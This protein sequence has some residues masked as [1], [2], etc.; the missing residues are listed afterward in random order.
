M[1]VNRDDHHCA[2][3]FN[4]VNIVPKFSDINSRDLCDTNVTFCGVDIEVPVVPANMATITGIQMIKKLVDLNM[5][6]IMHRFGNYKKELLDY[7]CTGTLSTCRYAMSI[8]V[9]NVEED[10]EFIASLPVWP[11]FVVIDVA[12][13]HHQKVARTIT[14]LKEL[15]EDHLPV[16]AGN[17]ATPEGAIFLAECGADAVK[18]GVGNGALCETRIRTGVGIP[19][20]TAIMTIKQALEKADMDDVQIIADGGVET[21]GDIAKAIAAGADLVMAGNIFSGTKETPGPLLKSGNWNAP[22]LYKQYAG[23]ASYAAKQANNQNTNHIEG[24]S[25]LVPYKGKCERIIREIKAGLQSAMSYVGART[26]KEF[27]EK[28]EFIRVTLNGTREAKPFLLD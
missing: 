16:V 9:N 11:R 22:T 3:T 21:P 5:I 7:V 20:L 19:Q 26:I 17:I 6:G 8:G 23:S 24:N 14:A 25:K 4:D 13:G 12:H 27:Q 1:Y 18:V 15:F 2:L 10:C 28:A